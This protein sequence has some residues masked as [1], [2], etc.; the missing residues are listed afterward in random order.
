MTVLVYAFFAVLAINLVPAFAPPTWM[1]LSFI[2]INFQVPHILLLVLA[3]ALGAALGRL[4]LAKLS[5]LIIRQHLLSEKT[6]INIDSLRNHLE[7]NKKLTYG[8]FLFYALSPLPSNQLFIAYGLT[9]LK[10]RYVAWPF[11]LGRLCSYTLWALMASEVAKRLAS[12]S[13]KSI[14]YFSYYFVVSQALIFLVI[15][16][17]MKLDWKK[18]LEEKKLQWLR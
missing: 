3:G 12:E 5:Y 17:F 2:I 9:S 10:V 15:Y 11:F 18:L 1:V 14:S 16:L 4:V 13:L 6:K 7:G 8:I